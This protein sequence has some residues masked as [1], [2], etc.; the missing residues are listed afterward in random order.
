LDEKM[1]FKDIIYYKIWRYMLSCGFVLLGKPD[2]PAAPD[3]TAAAKETAAGNLEAAKVAAAAN[4]V[5]QVTPYGNLTYTQNPSQGGFDQA[6]Y[7]AAMKDYQA[8][9]SGY[10]RGGI[11]GGMV[12]GATG[13]GMLG[14]RG[15][16]PI[17]PDRNAFMKNSG[18]DTYTA[19]Q[20]LSPAEQSKLDKNNALSLGLLDTAQ[21]GLG[22]VNEA[23]QKGF[24]WEALPASQVNAG[25]T[26]QD[27][28][29]A[30][31]NPQFN[32]REDALRTRLI[33]QGVRPGTEAWD[34]EFRNFGQDRND[35][36]SQAALYGIDVGNKARQQALQE[37]EFGRT[38]GLNMVNALR[39]G[40]QV[41]QPN[42]VNTPQQA[43]TAG[44][45][46][47]GAANAQYQGQL[48]AYNAQQ[49]GSNGF[50]GGLGS[51]AG[52]GAKFWAA[53]NGVPSY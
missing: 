50:L 51:L 22:G 40:N 53:S 49:A 30:R 11:G 19:T 9:L 16:A 47:L 52:A 41:Q 45:D 4:R 34:N 36:T 5:N 37:Q 15:A 46:L 42:F 2:A 7:D 28:I 24:N 13:S 10:S 43:T 32:T 21:L 8:K 26:A 39:T 14:G 48:G 18:Y 29:M 12:S 6:G 44:A 20:T 33:N 38:E 1:S 25:Q 31:I 23:L 35:A 27:A 3:Y 17:A